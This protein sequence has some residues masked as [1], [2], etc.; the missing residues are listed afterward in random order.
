LSSLA[1]E[2]RVG[3]SSPA[4]RRAIRGWIASL[5]KLA[6]R[7]SRFQSIEA[8]SG[9]HHSFFK[10]WKKGWSSFVHLN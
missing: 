8:K 9:K 3:S 2:K 5:A 1:D 7:G 10:A 6:R 4:R